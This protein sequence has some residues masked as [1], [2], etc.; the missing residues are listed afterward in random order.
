MA[1]PF[2]T[3]SRL[4][5]D[6]AE[7]G[8]KRR[9]FSSTALRQH[10]RDEDGGVIWWSMFTIVGMLMATG[11]GITLQFYEINRA[12]LQNT[13]DRAVLAATDLDQTIDAEDVIADYVKRA[14]LEGALTDASVENGINFRTS[15]A[16][17]AVTMNTIFT[18]G[19][20]RWD[21]DAESRAIESITDVEIALVL[22]NSGSMGWSNN[23]RLNL[24][25]PA[26]KTFVD[27]VTRPIDGIQN[28]S[29]TVSIVPFS[30]QVN[31]G[32]LLA[33][34]LSFS[35][36][37]TYSHC[38]RFEEGDYG[39]TAISGSTS[40]ERAGHFDIF[41]WDEPVDTFG[42]VCPFDSSRH[43]TPWARE[44]DVLKAQIDA[45]W[46][47]GNTSMDVATKWGASLLDPAMAPVFNSLS[48]QTDSGIID[49]LG[50]QP[51][52]YERENTLKVLVVMSDGQ[53]TD[54]FRLRDAY[55]SGKSPVF[56][57]PTTGEQSYFDEDRSNNPYYSLT[58]STWRSSPD[59]GSDAVQVD[60]VDLLNDMS[61]ARYALDIKSEAMGGGWRSYYDEM[62]T[63]VPAWQKNNRTSAIC[64]AARNAGIIVYTIGMD[65]YGQGDA[66]LADCA[67]TTVNFFDVSAVQIDEAFSAI[68]QQI[69]QLR[70]TQ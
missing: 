37:H 55:R 41:T 21:V 70:L 44:A 61:V 54:E 17:A 32:P 38:A 62:Y 43:I 60:W 66:T 27:T 22:D 53:N 45:M 9:L 23:Y 25:K 28:G 52:A 8:T 47:G 4:P 36:Q 2:F 3:S 34:E 48:D 24:L 20:D 26:A 63:R 42:V 57:D 13:L 46:A 68:A 40:L 35:D 49:P 30:T 10:A 19:I 69:N 33:D 6:P 14:G 5:A 58:D 59:G 56:E 15:S 11:L 29:V 7:D 16:E 64:A 51:F 50:S 39:S 18:P 12:N 1:L 65:T 31:A 67:G